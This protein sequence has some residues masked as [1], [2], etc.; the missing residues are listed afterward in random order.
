MQLHHQTYTRLGFERLTDLVPLCEK[1]HKATHVFLKQ[2][3]AAGANRIIKGA[4]KAIRK[5]RQREVIAPDT[6]PVRYA[7][8][9]AAID[10]IKQR[11]EADSRCPR[12][13]L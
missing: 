1:C 6:K 4:H 8:Q 2:C 9:N 12:T 7:Q 10:A 5:R 11:I 13:M 3:K